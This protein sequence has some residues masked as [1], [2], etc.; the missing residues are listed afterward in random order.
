MVLIDGRFSEYKMGKR[1]SKDQLIT[2]I[3]SALSP[4]YFISYNRSWEFVGDLGD[5]KKKLDSLVANGEAERAVALFEIFL[6]GCYEKAEEI[7]G[8]DGSF[9]MFF[10]ELL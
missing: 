8:S 9:G 6:A 5:M 4:G 2:E 3:E 7:D 1:K 10:H